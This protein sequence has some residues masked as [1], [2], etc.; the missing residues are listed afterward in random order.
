MSQQRCLPLSRRRKRESDD[1]NDITVSG[2][3]SIDDLEN[4]DAMAYL[5]AVSREAQYL[6]EVFVSSPPTSSS[7]P[8]TKGN[9]RESFVPIDGS[10]AAMSY[11]L[12]NR[13]NF[14][15]PPSSLHIP[16][17]GRVW[18]EHTCANF[19]ELRVYLDACSAAGLAE[20]RSFAV[21]TMKDG[22]RWH[23][24]CLGKDEAMGNAG[25]YFDDDE[26][27]E[28]DS[29]CDEDG[30]EM[31]EV[32]N[33]IEGNDDDEMGSDE[34]DKNYDNDDDKWREN[35]PRRGHPPSV[36]LLCQLDQVM[37][38]RVLMHHARFLVEEG[39]DLSSTRGAWL[40][41]LLARLD[42]P[43]HRDEEATLTSVLRECC[44]RRA[45]LKVESGKIVEGKLLNML[46][47]LIA[48]I[49]VYFEQ[50]GRIDDLLLKPKLT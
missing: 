3:L 24:F 45:D 21:P 13:M 48:V 31:E 4:M 15:P 49:G 16:K 29:G 38:R 39:Y 36:Q 41:G 23:E 12:S 26:D 28:D 19:S 20:K 30:D 27:V 22:A 44:K 40:Y 33:M 37:T 42:K 17:S 5:A 25:G 34:V 32:E 43:L 11:M 8:K 10:A 7:S 9:E 6:P 47:V 46:N 18:V 14:E 2:K 35:I 1:E 50:G